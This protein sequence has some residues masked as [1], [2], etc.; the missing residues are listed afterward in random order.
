MPQAQAQELEELNR[1]LRQCNL[2]QFIQQ[3]GAALPPAPQPDRA[4]PGT[5]DL[6]PPARERPLPGGPQSPALVSSLSPE[7]MCL[8]LTLG[9]TRSACGPSAPSACGLSTVAPMRQNSWR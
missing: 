1:E 7:G 3:T 2:Q 8:C 4:P 5:Q 9:G 6:M